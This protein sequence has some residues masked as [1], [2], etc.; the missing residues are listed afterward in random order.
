MFKKNAVYITRSYDVDNTGPIDLLNR[1]SSV[2]EY[3]KIVNTGNDC[4]YGHKYMTCY[5]DTRIYDEDNDCGYTVSIMEGLRDCQVFEANGMPRADLDGLTSPIDA[6]DLRQVF[7]LRATPGAEGKETFSNIQYMGDI[8]P[9]FFNTEDIRN[10]ARTFISS[11]MT[12]EEAKR[13][14]DVLTAGLR[15]LQALNAFPDWNTLQIDTRPDAK[16]FQDTLTRIGDIFTLAGGTDNLLLK[17]AGGKTAAQLLYENMFGFVPVTATGAAAAAGT[18]RGASGLGLGETPSEV[19]EGEVNGGLFG[20]GLGAFQEPTGNPPVETQG[21]IQQAIGNVKAIL[22]TPTEAQRKGVDV[23]AYRSLHEQL[24]T[25]ASAKTLGAAL[26]YIYANPQVAVKGNAETVRSW[27]DSM[28]AATAKATAPAATQSKGRAQSFF[29]ARDDPRLADLR[30]HGLR[31]DPRYAGI[32]GETGLFAMPAIHAMMNPVKRKTKTLASLYEDDEDVEGIGSLLGGGEGLQRGLG[33]IRGNRAFNIRGTET[34]LRDRLTDLDD[35][36]VEID[37]LLFGTMAYNLDLLQKSSL[38]GLERMVSGLYLF[39]PWRRQ[40]LE[41]WLAR[42]IMPNFGILGF[43]IGL[44]DMALG[45]K[46]SF[47]LLSL[48]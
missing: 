16:T 42:N 21:L 20:G 2:G 17:V 43:R 18:G 24:G 28:R 19:P 13:L 46:V 33:G 4:E 40:T 26:D 23:A 3:F 22:V 27:V 29:L 7:W 5:T 41:G 11:Q 10:W 32:E 47:L 25:R 31:I 38:S 35:E 39:A 9:V 37:R 12:A 1:M 48:V 34:D 8:D 6:N 30:K 44:Y 36:N 14:D 15:N 45:I